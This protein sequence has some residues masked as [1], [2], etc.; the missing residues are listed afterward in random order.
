MAILVTG[1]AG[2]GKSLF[3][4]KLINDFCD[5]NILNSSEYLVIY[6]DLKSFYIEG[7]QPISVVQ[8]LQDSM[9][10]ETLMDEK[11]FPIDMIEY[12]IKMGRCLIYTQHV[13]LC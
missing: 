7:E 2:Y 4:K 13:L 11:Y 1:G 8:F 6:G 12:Y 9:V 3:L 10:K 5:M